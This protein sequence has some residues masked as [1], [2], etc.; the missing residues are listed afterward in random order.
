MD[1]KYAKKSLKYFHKQ[2]NDMNKLWTKVLYYQKYY[3]N[4]LEKYKINIKNYE[5]ITTIL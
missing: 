3:I 1:L 2:R 4:E 5:K